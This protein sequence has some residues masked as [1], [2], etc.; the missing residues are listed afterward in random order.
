MKNGEYPTESQEG[1]F[2][3]PSKS[4]NPRGHVQGKP[5]LGHLQRVY[6]RASYFLVY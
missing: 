4:K 3:N 5:F 6:T 2:E 1:K